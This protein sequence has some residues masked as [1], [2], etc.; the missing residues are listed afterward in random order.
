MDILQ[1]IMPAAG[2][3]IVLIAS[4]GLGWLANS[5][6]GQGKIASADAQAEKIIEDAR[7]EAE[8]LKKTALLEAKDEW[9]KA[10]LDFDR[11]TDEKRNELRKLEMQFVDRERK[12]DKK[13]DILNN[14]E[15]NLQI[16]EQQLSSR[17][18]SIKV[19]DEQLIQIISEQNQRLE[20]ISRMTQDEAQRI[21][22]ANLE[23]KV[24]REGARRA[25]EIKDEAIS[26]AEREAREILV[27]AI[28]RCAAD[29]SVESTVSIVSLPSD[30][31]KGRIIG[32]EGR[33]IRVFE[34]RTGVD[35]IVDDTPEAVIL[36][37][38]DP[39]RR[40][41]AR[42]SLE[43]LILDGRIHP[44]RIE[45]VVEKVEAEIDD[46]IKEAGEQAAFE[47]GVHGLHDKLIV[48]LG[49]LKYRT[50]FG[51]NVLQHSKEVA[52]L[53]GM[54]AAELGLDQQLAKRSGLLHDIGKAV[55]HEV[56]G[57][58]VEIGVELAK[59]H[60]EHEVVVNAIEAH[61]EGVPIISPITAIVDAANDISSA[62]PGARRDTLEGYVKRLDHL[63][64]LAESFD[65][66]EKTYAIQAGREVRVITDCKLLDDAQAD[67]LASDI[68]DKIESQLEY[69]DQIKV[70]V[71]REIRAVDYAR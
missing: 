29:H 12:M 50:S 63:E 40:E 62:R 28:Q 26:N 10:K 4:F 33:N 54:M 43:R 59:R 36:S 51:Q 60:R 8:S 16:R 5:R 69:P 3:V 46:K 21:L 19:K 57:T 37:S 53:A 39:I 66:V 31:M 65:G 47:V 68:A 52:L 67:Q 64:E 30:E 45:E 41:I 1:L 22:M 17:E 55:D 48:F 58:H 25:K 6:A 42:I 56:E 11:N 70:T 24:K 34:I 27:M 35:V 32:R 2:I 15:K 14:K 20:K 9:Y 7:E 44:G 38:F 71:I 61:H 13:V 18:R 49:K 23:D